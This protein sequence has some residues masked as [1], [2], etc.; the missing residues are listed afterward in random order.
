[1]QFKICLILINGWFCLTNIN[2]HT[3][4][5]A[6]TPVFFFRLGSL[7]LSSLLPLISLYL[8]ITVI[9]ILLERTQENG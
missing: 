6:H 1:M 8:E 4:F 7:S 2:K 5:D 3:K 9:G